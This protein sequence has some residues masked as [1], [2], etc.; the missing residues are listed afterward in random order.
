MVD[1]DQENQKKS[2]YTL[3]SI[4]KF[5]RWLIYSIIL[6]I[7]VLPTLFLS[8]IFLDEETS[9]FEIPTLKVFVEG[10]LDQQLGQFEIT[11]GKG[12]ISKGDKLF[13]PKFVFLDVIIDDTANDGSYKF[14]HVSVNLDFL[15]G[16]NK[17][18]LS[19][20][21]A[22]LFIRRD[23]SGK[24]NI[25]SAKSNVA[26]NS[27]FFKQIDIS[28]NSF[29]KLPV[30]GTIN[31]FSAKNITIKY[32]D[33]KSKKSY[34][35][36]NGNL[37]IL[38]NMQ[39]LS[40]SSSFDLMNDNKDKSVFNISG[41]HTINNNV[42]NSI[43]KVENADPITLADNITA[44]DW[45]RNVETNVNSS[46][47]TSFDQNGKILD[48]D[49]VIELGAGQLLATPKYSSSKFTYAKTY[50]EYD[51]TSDIIDFSRFEFKSKQISASGSA[52]NILLRDQNF[53]IIGLNTDLKV[54]EIKINRP[55][56][57]ENDT[58]FLDSGAAEIITNFEPF[59]I[60]IKKSDVKID[61]SNLYIT[62]NL[63]AED[64]FWESN[65]NVEIDKLNENNIKDLWPINYKINT[66][67][68]VVDNLNKSTF[69][70]IKGTILTYNGEN[71]LDFVFNF[72]D[73]NINVIKSL[74]PLK[75]IS[76]DG[77]L[78]TN[79]ITFNLNNGIFETSPG[80]F[81]D[82][83]GSIFHIS[84]T[85][86]KPSIGQL[87]LYSN[88]KL[89]SFFELLD[90]KK[91][92]YL[93]K[94]GFKTDVVQGKVELEGWVEWPLVKGVSQNQLEFK[95][96]GIL[97]NIKSKNVIKN[98][99]VAAKNLTLKVSDKKL[100]IFGKSKVDD[101]PFSFTW[102]QNLK[103]NIERVST[104][105]AKF[106]IDQNSFDVFNIELPQNMFLGSANAN[107][108]MI[109][110]PKYPSK[111]IINSKLK[112]AEINVNSLGWSNKNIKNGDLIVRGSLSRPV[113]ID[114][115][116]ISVDD[117]NVNGKINFEN[118][119]RFK[120]AVFPVIKV[121]D[122]FSSSITL[123]KSEDVN[124]MELQ[125][126]KVDFRQLVFGKSDNTEVGILK[127]AL[128]S[129][130]ISDGIELTNF[131]SE[132]DFNK[133]DLGSFKAQINGGAEI[134]GNLSKGEFGTIVSLNGDDAGHVLRSA[135]I[136]KN[137]R[138]GKINLVLTPNEKDGYYTGRFITNKFR[139]LHS[140]PLALLLDSLSLVGLL[141]KLKNEG[142]QFDQAKGWLNITPEGIQLRDV[143]LVGLSMGMSITGWYDKQKKSINFDGVV[144]PVYAIN[145]VFER[146]AG[147]L[148]G[149][150]KGEGLFSFVYT[151]KG[152]TSSPRVEVKPL[153][154]LTPGGFRKIFREDIPAPPK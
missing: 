106:N 117:L 107:L 130:R 142:I 133:K 65:F 36:E 50:F 109:L 140:N 125:G 148:F 73:A 112:G 118:D 100:S 150:Q 43:F 128:D 17:G 154:I 110:K 139:M 51:L 105:D 27:N 68:W 52:K 74:V 42:F 38:K 85:K 88:G 3:Q 67:R 5:F 57:F 129:L 122:W 136:L 23:L 99:I 90:S 104:L 132:I 32:E 6:V 141:D 131:I 21:N 97:S 46:I 12:G 83:S 93:K 144:T 145:G 113:D 1:I 48:M 94:A 111:F 102:N 71:E 76:G 138:G 35:F 54:A 29:L 80:F 64:Y 143:S 56:I 77:S 39:D 22:Q 61:E 53:N 114:E 16:S 63:A 9:F 10:K 87:K 18:S 28:T 60:N 15:Y 134:Y 78:T 40:L 72:D 121:A 75:H 124:I 47:I 153:S 96:E 137:I 108:K 20:D 103:N 147:K 8:Y 81:T 152:P 4:T 120:S 101:L 30:I 70:D 31:K 58:I 149:E 126:G 7:F 123:S 2:I 26:K 92:E 19:I 33:D 151:M 79:Q 135:G 41:N 14:P 127:V 98:R 11:L 62:G 49:G 146:L 37:N 95:A 119:G 89:K 45:L 84:D 82:I 59:I 66:R 44:L 25:A 91:F 115:I 13:S 86:A 69:S 116:K 24:F 34:L 55:D